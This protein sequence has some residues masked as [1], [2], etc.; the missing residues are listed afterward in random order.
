M[1]FYFG[2]GKNDY[3]VINDFSRK[4]DVIQLLGDESDYMLEKVSRREGL[5]TGTGI[6]YIGSDGPEDLIGIIKGFSASRLDL[7]EDYF[8]FV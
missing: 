7:G 3:A 8:K 2:R 6:Y 5:P 4:R 1:P